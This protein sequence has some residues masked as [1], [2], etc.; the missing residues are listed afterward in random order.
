MRRRLSGVFALAGRLLA[1]CIL[2]HAHA[3]MGWPTTP[4]TTLIS[5]PK[6]SARSNFLSSGSNLID[7]LQFYRDSVDVAVQSNCLV[8]HRAGG[9]APLS[10]A[11]LVVSRSAEAN[12]NAFVGFLASPG[13]SRDYIL[14]KITGGNGHGGGAITFQG[15]AFYNS[16]DQY[17][18][19]LDG[20]G[21]G[22]SEEEDFWRGTESETRDVTLRRAMLLFSGQVASDD[23]LTL[24]E[25]SD[26]NLRAQVMTAMQGDG[27]REFLVNGANDQLLISGL[28]NGIDFNISTYD[29]YPRLAELMRDLP[30]ERPEEFEEYHER[31]YFTRGDA[32]WMFRQA[33]G[34]EPLEL[35]AHVVMNDLPYSEV[36]TADYT[37]VNA[38]SDL[39]YR[40]EAGFSHEFAGEDGFYD[41]RPFGIFRPGYN[42]GHIPHDEQF[43]INEEEGTFSFSDY[44]Q[45]PHAGVLSTHAWLARYPSTATNRNRARA[46]WTYFHFLGVDVEKS[47]P[48]STD[49]D[50]LADTDNPTM[51]NPACTVCHESLD[52]VAG[53]YQSFGDIGHYL[54]QFGGEDSLSDAYKCPECYG[55]EPGSTDYQWGDT[56]YRDMRAPGFEGNP[57]ETDFQDSLQW[58]AQ[59]IV[60]DPRFAA[61]TVQFWWPAVFGSELLVPPV[62]A[63]GDDAA[64]KIRAFNAQQALIAELADGFQASGF[65]LKSLLADMV[66]SPWYRH[67]ILTDPAVLESRQIELATVG[68]GKL[69]T[70]EELDRKNRA[71]FGR[72][73]R[74]WGDGTN[75]HAIGLETAFVGQWAPYT[76]FYGGI[77]GAVVTKRNRNLTPLM[78]NV[79]ESM[80]IDLACQVVIEDFNR[81]RSER[82]VFHSIDRETVPG[83]INRV[84]TLLRGKVDDMGE[85]VT[86]SVDFDARF[87][88]GPTRLRVADLTRDSHESLDSDWTGAELIVRS[89]G[90]LQNG[91]T[92]ERFWGE[93]FPQASG[94]LADQ[95]TDE[96]GGQHW[97]GHADNEGWRMHPGAWVEIEVDVDAGEYTVEVELA[98]SLLRNNVNDAMTA[99]LIAT[100]TKNIGQTASG[101]AIREQISDI[102]RDAFHRT[103]ADAEVDSMLNQLVAS[104]EN[105]KS[106]TSW[107]SD[108]GNHCETWAIWQH[109]ELDHQGYQDRYGDSAGMMRGWTTLVHSVMTSY[110][111][112]HD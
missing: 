28:A 78:S 31:P 94:F 80:A 17:L 8:C 76:T 105:A 86:H 25:E 50:A 19:L 24:A 45:W 97:R 74:Q 6:E 15:S 83:E 89:I 21:E 11:G 102:V 2:F 107:F 40:S 16:L 22:E 29:R 51:R 96:E 64:Q 87:V 103:P 93:K 44:Q 26:E 67:S 32:E 109:E 12:H 75:A 79:A 99:H 7:P 69:L 52:P 53:A 23:T 73:W 37:M 112:L 85:S 42:D 9:A 70:P 110:G 59:E 60:N 18:A 49:P 10:G 62:E 30:D 81:P 56:W 14:S 3:A 92:V 61:A 4:E 65:D 47:A 48:R 104:A 38:F 68:R 95:W 46:R 106:R 90:L 88:G 71:V 100:A 34:R 63:E 91:V 108:Q 1:L 111:Y 77:D 55:G 98:T 36:L 43:E 35:I 33:V 13:I 58:L 101:R 27:F 39:A 57:A 84:K 54:D 5:A 66:M 72:S 82:R 41:R 20:N